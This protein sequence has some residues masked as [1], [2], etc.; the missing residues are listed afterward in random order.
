LAQSPRT[1]EA[2]DKRR[3]ILR[4]AVRVFSRKGYDAS[5]VSDIAREA[6][7]AYGLVYHYFENKEDVLNSI[8][9]EHLGLLHE[10]I[11]TIDRDQPGAREKLAAIASFVID[12][13]R[14]GADVVRVLLLEVVRS[15]MLVAAPRAD[16]VQGLFRR[17]EGIVR[18]HQEEG[19]LRRDLD[20]RMV[21]YVFL[22]ALETLLTGFALGTLPTSDEAFERAKR[23]VVEIA[24]RGL[25]G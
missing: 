1:P 14:V 24:W 10:A 17:V 7:V 3:T 22:G 9:R 2:R 25:A 23:A 13:Y 8:F 21:T 6:G 4:A 5:R 12:G 16:A 18:R 11:A 15:S 19:A 20:P